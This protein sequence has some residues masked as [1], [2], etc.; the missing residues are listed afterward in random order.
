MRASVIS[1]VCLFGASTA[2]HAQVDPK[3]EACP[4]EALAK[5]LYSTGGR[6]AGYNAHLAPQRAEFMKAC[7]QRR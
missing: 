4:K 1:T 6:N 2:A 3:R 5:G 7:M